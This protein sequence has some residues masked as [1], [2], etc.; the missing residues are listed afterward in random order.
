MSSHN[1][2]ISFLV[3]GIMAGV[4]IGGTVGWWLK[5]VKT[6]TTKILTF[7]PDSIFQFKHKDIG[8]LKKIKIEELKKSQ[9]HKYNKSSESSLTYDSSKD[10]FLDSLDNTIGYSK[11][12]S[13]K[14]NSSETNN[15]REIIV[16]KDELLFVKETS[17]SV[18]KD[19]LMDS[20]LVDATPSTS[21]KNT[22]KIEFWVSPVN[23]R[24]YKMADNKLIIYGITDFSETSLIS[25]NN[26]FYLKDHNIYFPLEITSIFKPLVKLTNQNLI[27]QI[28]SHN[29]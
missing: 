11:K 29:K 25:F 24:G 13:S 6:L 19:N 26:S 15:E 7:R 23:Y 20:L 10:T 3:I 4:L 8:E 5:P 27:T 22:I 12:D 14:R 2:N 1:K 21:S 16:K 17:F 9:N 18:K 28:N